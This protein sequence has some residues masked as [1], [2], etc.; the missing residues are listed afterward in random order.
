MPS[1]PRLPPPVARPVESVRAKLPASP[2]LV[3]IVPGVFLGNGTAAND[4][5]MLAAAGITHV[6]NAASSKVPSPFVG[7]LKY[8]NLDVLDD[9]REQLLPYVSQVEAFVRKAKADGGRVLI[10]CR[11]GQSRSPSLLIGYLMSTQGLSF[12]AARAKVASK[13]PAIDPWA[14]EEQLREWK[15]PRPPGVVDAF[16]SSPH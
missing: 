16:T 13:A 1:A 8:L 4:R 14:F 2:L 11:L 3:E 10:H 9:P 15:P 12:D 5:A 7:E 6:V